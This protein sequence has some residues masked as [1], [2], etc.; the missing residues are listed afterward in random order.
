MTYLHHEG[1]WR[2]RRRQALRSR[3][4]ASPLRLHPH[5]PGRQ[6]GG[7]SISDDRHQRAVPYRRG[8]ARDNFGAVTG[9]L[10]HCLSMFRTPETYLL[11]VV[12]WRCPGNRISSMEASCR[13][14]KSRDS[15]TDC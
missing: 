13:L 2:D 5:G 1:A 3:A 14:R 8:L 11:G 7:H 9:S 4:A 10:V 15:A 12:S 6:R